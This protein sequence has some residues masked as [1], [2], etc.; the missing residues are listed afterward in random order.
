[1]KKFLRLMMMVTLVVSFIGFVSCE[2]SDDGD[3]D[4]VL[5]GNELSGS[6]S[7]ALTLDASVEYKLTGPVLIEDGGV[8]NIPAGTVIKAEK[9]FN[10]YI[11]VLQLMKKL[12]TVLIMAGLL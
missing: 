6:L 8:L 7:G 12:E 5:K 3:K 4:S 9:G 10:K 11:L 2:K 1:M